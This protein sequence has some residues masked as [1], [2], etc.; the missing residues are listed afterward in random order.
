M[1]LPLAGGVSTDAV[2]GP[3]R[4]GAVARHVRSDGA[5]GSPRER[6]LAAIVDVT[7]EHGY[8][9]ATIAQVVTRARVSR[10]TFYE[11]FADKDE[12]FVVALYELGQRLLAVVAGSISA[13][14][15]ADAANAAISALIGYAEE[16][17][18]D[19]RVLMNES[20]AGGT[21]ALDTRDCGVDLIG[22]LIDEACGH[23]AAGQP[24]PDIPSRLL[25]GAA[26]RMLASRL[27]RGER[28]LRALETDLLQW[29]DAYRRPLGEHRWRASAAYRVPARSPFLP[30]APLRPPPALAPGRPRY[31]AAAVA[32]N[33]RLRI[34]F[35][36]A[37]IVR[38][39]G[40]KA[41]TI[42]EIT[43]AASVDG[44]A[45]YALFA[46][47]RDVFGAVHELGYQR[48][49]A[50]TAGAFFA[51]EDWPHRIWEAGRA[52]LQCME[53][54][55][56]LAHA[57]LIESH[58]GGA[59][60]IQRFEDLMASFTIFL[61]EGYQHEPPGTLPPPTET[62]L[63]AIAAANLES[64]YREVRRDTERGLSRLLAQLAYVCLAPFI[65]PVEA[66]ER[67][68]AMLSDERDYEP[69]RRKTA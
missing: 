66:G 2:C 25:V 17:P 44:R 50:V 35:A 7:A 51:A 31:S 68:D 65:G 49:M 56:T 15:P 16:S 5:G 48:T 64:A 14:A 34:L 61:Q 37:E 27:R 26:H 6:L 53:Q 32:E 12:C 19:A 28:G 54:N 52:F 22:A 8:E 33:Q 38:R 63:Q 39:D 24:V 46:D 4:R 23:L 47:K 58:A 41:A 30:D 40:Y 57:S 13:R 18:T 10:P 43:R 55:P 9:Q 62:A 67:I 69:A 59:D 3:S 29:L 42:A 1:R 21:Q 60:T 11:H 36:T 20:M 45:F